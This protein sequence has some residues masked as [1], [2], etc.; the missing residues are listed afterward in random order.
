MH[1]F[2]FHDRA[3]PLYIPPVQPAPPRIT[4]KPIAF[5]HFVVLP[6]ARTLLLRGMPVELGGRAFDLLL[7]LL[8][9]RGTIVGKDQLDA[10]GLARHLCR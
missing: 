10:R 6:S 7:V 5:R 1:A 4:R 2:A 9:A 3:N 8:R